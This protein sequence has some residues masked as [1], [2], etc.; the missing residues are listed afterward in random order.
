MCAGGK[1]SETV[2]SATEEDCEECEAGQTSITGAVECVAGTTIADTADH[3]WDFRGCA[4]GVPVV[5]APE[6][7]DLQATLMN[8]A[9]CTSE[10]VAFDGV[11]DYVDLDDWEWGGAFTIEVYVKPERANWNSR[12]LDFGSGPN[13]DGVLLQSNDEATNG[14][15]LAVYRGSA[16]SWFGLDAFWVLEGWTH[17][18]ITVTGTSVKV[19][20]D[21]TLAGGSDSFHEP[22]VLTRTQNWLG[23]SQ[24]PGDSYLHGSIAYV[25]MWHGVGLQGEEVEALF[26]ETQI[27]N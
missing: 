18:V 13:S 8:G 15:K 1:Y 14:F 22:A 4:D 12:V 19:Y 23:R 3:A 5:D 7:S 17:T 20:K 11:D 16:G 6:A 25:R 10:G 24:W 26:N 2:G 21:G 27:T 9:S